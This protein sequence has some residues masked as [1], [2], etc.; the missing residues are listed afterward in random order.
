[1][2]IPTQSSTTL[3][4]LMTQIDGLSDDDLLQLHQ[5]IENRSIDIQKAKLNA[6][7]EARLQHANR[8]PSQNATQPF[9]I[10]QLEEA[11]ADIREGLSPEER[12]F[13]IQMMIGDKP[14]HD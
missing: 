5:L 7:L 13:I 12:E 14:S 3:D 4:K 11:F 6:K 2:A 9:D 10:E 1:M 8:V